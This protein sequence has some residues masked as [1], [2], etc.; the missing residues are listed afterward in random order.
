MRMVAGLGCPMRLKI[1]EGDLRLGGK[2]V[3]AWGLWRRLR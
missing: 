2:L 3:P 1:K